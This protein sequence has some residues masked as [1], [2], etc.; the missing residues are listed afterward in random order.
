MQESGKDV[1]KSGNT[2]GRIVDIDVSQEMEQS[3]LAYAYSVI[4]SRALP[5]ARDGL[6]PVQRRILYQMNQ[7]GL[8]PDKGHVKSSRVVGEVM[9][10]LHPHGDSAIY[11]ALVRLAQPF[12]M[13][14]ELVDGHGNFGSLD[15]GPAASRYTE[16]R[17][18]PGAIDMCANLDEDVVDF[19]PNYDN[20]YQE[21]SVLPTTFP[22][23]LVNGVEGI[24]VGMATKIA[25]HNLG[26]TISAAI[27]LLDNPDATLDDLMRY[28]PG[29]DFPGGGIIVGLSGIREAYETGRGS[30]KIRARAA[31]EQVSPRK[32]GIVITELPFMIGP[33]KVGEKLKDA[34]NKGK[35]KGVSG[36]Q[37]LSDRKHGM[38]LVVEIKNSFHPEAVLEQLYK[39]T[40]LEDSFAF[41]SVAL[42]DGQPRTLG[43]K[44]MLQVFVEHRVEVTRRRSEFRLRKSRDRAH[45]VDGLLIA[46]LNID[47]VIEVIRSSDDSAAA[48]AKL[49]KV[50]DLSEAQAQYILELRLRRLTKFSRIELENEAAEL[51]E[52]I[53]NL[54]AI[55]ADPEKLRDVVRGELLE[56]SARLSTPRRTVLIDDEGAGVV[57][58]SSEAKAPVMGAR[59]GADVP[60]EIPD[61]P[62]LL[63]LTPNG[64]VARISGEEPLPRTGQRQRDDATLA[65]LPCTTRSEV[66]VIT[67]SGQLAKLAVVDAPALP[68]T[69]DAPS[70]SGAIEVKAL[71]EWPAGDTPVGLVS[72]DPE[73]D[74]IGLITKFG[75]IKRVR[76][77]HPGNK[78][79]W[80]IMGLEEGD[81]IVAGA[82]APDN[83]YFVAVTSDAQLL[84][85]P[86]DKVRPQG[87]S[88]T[89]VAGIAVREGCAVIAGAI[90]PE[91][92]LSASVVVTVAQADGLLAGTAQTSVKVS[93][94]DRY[95]IKGR[96][97]QGV[98]AQRFLRGE[99]SLALAWVGLEPARAL[100]SRGGPLELPEVDERRDGSGQSIGYQISSLG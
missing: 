30:L 74:P 5:D 80:E 92:E 83:T 61:E 17:L 54:E 38:R 10:K 87:R 3:F 28:V 58:A 89:G 57:A 35:V 97:S 32:R 55:L 13:R 20:Q 34:I 45:L 23:L 51:K 71:T 63:V 81:A 82:P 18:A 93:P 31:V 19:L 84:R 27:E 68:R 60:L 7:M 50:F 11:E 79:C 77:E 46:V 43:L 15:D 62:C 72:L 66:G 48:C 14:L 39:H 6:K 53:S 36:W 69:E 12:T 22:N 52:T 8:R 85:T 56:V 86:A 37:D 70:F 73:S 29:P 41:N 78:G 59:V 26:E 21:P 47:E 4:Y 98:R 1:S 94:L 100:D 44:E 67:S 9:G 40:P 95:P 96:G 49:M 76:P 25:P 2:H 90:V 33:E 24:A 99:D 64:K 88:A 16:A 75:T 42:V 65:I 91:E